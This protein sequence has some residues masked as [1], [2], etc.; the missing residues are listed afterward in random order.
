M[1]GYEFDAGLTGFPVGRYKVVAASLHTADEWMVLLVDPST[2]KPSFKR[3]FSLSTKEIGYLAV[4]PDTLSLVRCT[5][6]RPV[7][8]SPPKLK[9]RLPNA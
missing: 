2:K 3:C 9:R 6:S 7:T 8:V 5:T 1:V 4:F